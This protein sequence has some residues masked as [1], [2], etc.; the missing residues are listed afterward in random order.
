MTYSRFVAFSAA[1]LLA[2]TLG[3][4]TATA[5]VTVSDVPVTAWRVNGV[6]HAVV[7]VGNTTYVGGSFT[8]ATAPNGTT[9]SRANVA[10][11]D[12]RTGA[13]VEGF[14]ADTNGMVRALVSDGTTLWIGGSF[15]TV[16]GESR[17]RLAAVDAAS[18]AVR[19]GFR[20]NASSHVHAL[21]LR[22]GRLFVGGSFGT[23]ADTTRT[24]VGA[25][26][27]ATGALD[28]RFNPGAND[29]VN[30][31]RAN[32]NGSVVYLAGNFSTA[33][34]ASRSGV[35]AVSGTT[36]SAVAPAFSNTYRPTIDLDLNTDGTRL[37][38]AVAGAG[39]QVAAFDTSN[40]SRVWR[41]WADG[42]VQAVAFHD[43][44]VY[45]GFHESFQNDTS[46]RLLAAHASDG[47]LDAAFRP[48]FDRYWGVHA[49][50]AT[51]HGVAAAGDFT[52]VSNVP[53]QGLALFSQ[54]RTSS[55]K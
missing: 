54:S 19:T 4:G 15:T 47:S 1:M 52:R 33:G 43:N 50:S 51:S 53:A 2:L 38:A 13:L 39:N 27:P 49:I 6:T 16:G 22:A 28:S 35:A 26:D 34:G 41:R 20:A 18:G 7:I 29:T 10:A 37:F 12:T 17:G 21:D 25:V 3:A 44:T 46:L 45:F 14:R 36:G 23:L 5:A 40:G 9:R 8:T 55:T 30:A 11:F 42:D 48:T 24:R 31:V 32:H